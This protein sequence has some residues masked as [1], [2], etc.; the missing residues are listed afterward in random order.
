M[1]FK[2]YQPIFQL[3]KPMMEKH[4]RERMNKSMNELKERIV[5]AHPHER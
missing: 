4:R 3:K 1:N 2:K 5:H